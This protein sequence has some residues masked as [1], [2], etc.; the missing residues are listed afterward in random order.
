[1]LD[2]MS[3]DSLSA[4]FLL[5][6]LTTNDHHPHLLLDCNPIEVECVLL[7]LAQWGARPVTHCRLPGP[8]MLPRYGRGTLFIEGLQHLN[9][10]QQIALFDWMTRRAQ[11]VQV[12]SVASRAISTS[13]EYST[14][15]LG[16]GV[17]FCRAMT[18]AR[19]LVQSTPGV[20]PTGWNTT[21]RSLLV[22][23]IVQRGSP[24]PSA[25]IRACGL[26]AMSF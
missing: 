4:S 23:L 12:I 11:N 16:I 14:E 9:L 13:H 18:T 8:L 2:Q 20:Q 15:P 22:A 3:F 21:E 26:N 24:S 10:T 19:M 1:M 7:G 6:S 5:R 25:A 17:R